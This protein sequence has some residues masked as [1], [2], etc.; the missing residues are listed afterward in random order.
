MR[1]SFEDLFNCPNLKSG[2]ISLLKKSWSQHPT[3]QKLCSDLPPILKTI[4]VKRTE[5]C[6]GSKDKLLSDVL[7]WTT[8]L[9]RTSVSWLAKTYI[10]QLCANTRCRPE[11]LPSTIGTD[12]VC[13]CERGKERERESQENLGC[14]RVLKSQDFVCW[15]SK[16]A[17]KLAFLALKIGVAY[18]F[19]TPNPFVLYRNDLSIIVFSLSLFISI[20]SHVMFISISLPKSTLNNFKKTKWVSIELLLVY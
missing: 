13:V 20:L 3:K 16:Q 11:D 2:S 4:Q 6:F 17:C 12:G 14:W 5:H 9:G 7:L 19:S 10:H 15:F 1:D 18:S 8:T